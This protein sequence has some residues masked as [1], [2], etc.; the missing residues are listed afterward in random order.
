MYFS[1][2]N[3]H[4]RSIG[5]EIWKLVPLINCYSSNIYVNVST[6]FIV[7]LINY[8]LLIFFLNMDINVILK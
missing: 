1:T 8:S 2:I 5:L 4:V 3:Y 7:H 6:L